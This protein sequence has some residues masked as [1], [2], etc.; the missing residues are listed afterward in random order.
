MEIHPYAALSHI[1]A[2]VF[3]GMTDDFPQELHVV[4][5]T[6]GSRELL[7]P[8]TRSEDW[9]GPFHAYG[10]TV[11]AL[12]GKPVHWH[13]LSKGSSVFGTAE[14]RPRGYPVRVTTPERTLL[15]G[16]LHP[17]WCGGFDNV[18]RAWV[19]ARDT[20]DLGAIVELVERFDVAVLR[21]RV[22][23][24]LEELGLEHPRVAE[25]P[26]QARRGGSSRLLGSAPFAPS[27]SERWKLSIN[28]P[29]DVLHMGA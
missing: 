12:F 2:F 8:G 25:W 28:A 11:D 21:Q 13:W 1:T 23:F 9:E 27:F 5:P 4:L 16:L 17:E 7:P 14:Y 22:G 3:H 10:R 19:H 18:L 29:I 26:A 15:D 20:L 24:I 6:E